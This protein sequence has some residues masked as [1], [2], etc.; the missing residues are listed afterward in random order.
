MQK[1]RKRGKSRRQ[2]ELQRNLRVL[3]FVMVC[4]LTVMGILQFGFHRYVRSHDDGRILSGVRVGG[5]DVSGMTQEEA[6]AAVKQVIA[7]KGAANIEF[8]LKNGNTFSASLGDLGLTA[9]NLEKAV[10]QAAGYGKN[11][12]AIAAYKIMKQA[13]EGKLEQ[14]FPLTCTVNSK[15]AADVLAGNAAAVLQ[16]PVN[17]AVTQDASGAVQIVEEKQGETLNVKKTVEN[18]NQFLADKWKGKGGTVQ[19]VV[20]LKAPEL[21]ADKLVDVTDLLGSFTTYYGSDGS[22]RSQNVETGAAHINGTLLQPGD[23]MSADEAMRPYTAENGYAEAASF[24]SDKVVQTM[25]GGICQVSTTLYDALLYAELEIV[26]RYPHSM[27]VS[28]VEPSMDAAIA[29]DLL[30]LV[31]KNNQKY[32]VYIEAV[33]SGGSLTFNIYGKETRDAARSLQFV[34]ETTE[35]KEPEGKRYVATE[36]YIGYIGLQSAAHSEISAQLWKVIY[37]NGEEASREVVNY[38]QY[39]A[40]PETYGVGTRSDNPEDTKKMNEA[41]TTQDETKI[42]S[43]IQEILYGSSL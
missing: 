29:D 33:L 16:Q 19:A 14:D 15:T 12:N 41:I 38:S 11:G 20:D 30:D 1:K 4:G 2:R 36:D 43:V 35:S 8:S 17:A 7:D 32:P 25:G 24:E 5:T 31:F 23:K 27:I 28:Y 37:E 10:S 42:N 40:A 39:A 34:S 9:S 26:E 3:A 6:L 21:T 18:L 22:G 13:R